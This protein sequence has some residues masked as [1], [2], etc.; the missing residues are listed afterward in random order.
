MGSDVRKP[1]VAGMFYPGDAQSLRELLLGWG[2][3]AGTA[4]ADAPKK[5]FRSP[6]GVIVPHAGYLYSGR[7]AAR[8][9]GWLAEQGRPERIVIL[10]ADHT[11]I[12][13]AVCTDEH[14]AWRTP[15][16]DAPIDRDACER[17][18]AAGVVPDG[19]AFAREHSIEVVLPFLQ[20]VYGATVSFVPIRVGAASASTYAQLGKALADV[21]GQHG[22]V[23]VS[24]DFTHYEPE[25][26]AHRTDRTVL[27]RICA[28]DVEGLSDLVANKRPSVCGIPSIMVALHWAAAVGI[29]QGDVLEYATSADVTGDHSAVVGYA[30]VGWGRSKE[31]HGS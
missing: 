21:A 8:G 13:A 14:S 18:A 28:L 4:A 23:V 9:I 20:A 5:T 16:G 6:F 10:G 19:A 12:G 27:D 15:F 25:D 29:T 2:L 30:A 17:L 31:R 3:G 24:S 11:G 1:L 22:A 7:I 26:A